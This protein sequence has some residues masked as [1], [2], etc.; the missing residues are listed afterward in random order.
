MAGIPVLLRLVSM[1]LIT[2]IV[3]QVL[4]VLF[5]VEGT[6]PCLLTNLVVVNLRKVCM[7]DGGYR[8]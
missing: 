5:V 4:R 2:I 6:T 1:V 3:I 7:E 8:R